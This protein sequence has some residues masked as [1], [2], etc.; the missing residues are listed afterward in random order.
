MNLRVTLRIK[1]KKVNPDLTGE[2]MT[3]CYPILEFDPEP[4]GI[5]EPKHLIKPMDVP[6]HCVVCFFAEVIE[7]LVQSSRV[8]KIA[9]SKSEIGEHP[10]YELDFQGRRLGLFHPGIG[11]PLAAEACLEL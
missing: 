3:E 2:K 1:V 10:L 5:L 4:E 11:A 8:R 9:A 7:G 6:E